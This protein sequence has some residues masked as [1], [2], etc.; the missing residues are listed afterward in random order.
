MPCRAPAS[1]SAPSAPAAARAPP[2]AR[3]P[4]P[5]PCART[6]ESWPGLRGCRAVPQRAPAEPQARAACGA[7]AAPQPRRTA[8]RR[9][10]SCDGLRIQLLAPGKMRIFA[11]TGMRSPVLSVRTMASTL[12]RSSMRKAPAGGGAAARRTRSG[13]AGQPGRLRHDVRERLQRPIGFGEGCAQVS[14]CAPRTVAAALGDALQ[15]A[16]EKAGCTRVSRCTAVCSLGAA[17]QGPPPAT[18]D[19]GAAEVDVDGVRDAARL[20]HARG[21]QQVLRVAGP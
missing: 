10:L 4:P 7:A 5:P 19:L 9:T 14:W 17:V 6:P 3:R 21:L 15:S 11:V 16:S 12:G 18:A 8:A 13:L 2:Q 20:N 1:S